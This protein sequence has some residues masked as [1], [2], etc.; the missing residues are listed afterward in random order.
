MSTE[1]NTLPE[2]FDTLFDAG[3][4]VE[5]AEDHRMLFVTLTK[6]ILHTQEVCDVLGWDWDTIPSNVKMT[7]MGHGVIVRDDCEA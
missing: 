4:C 5:I 3:F 2:I 6:S 1:I 7:Y